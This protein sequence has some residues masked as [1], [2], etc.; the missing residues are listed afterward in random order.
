M[1]LSFFMEKLELSYFTPRQTILLFTDSYIICLPLAKLLI[2]T[3]HLEPANKPNPG[4]V[5]RETLAETVMLYCCQSRD[6]I[7]HDG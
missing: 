4:F 7:D 5:H 1:C 2:V 3:D 6:K